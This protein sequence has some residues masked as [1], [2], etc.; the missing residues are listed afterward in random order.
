MTTTTEKMVFKDFKSAVDFAHKEYYKELP[1][2]M[3][4]QYVFFGDKYPNILEKIMSG[5]SLNEDEQKIMDAGKEYKHTVYRD[6]DVI[7]DAVDIRCSEDA[8]KE[9][10]DELFKNDVKPEDIEKLSLDDVPEATNN[11]KIKEIMV[12]QDIKENNGLTNF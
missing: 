3:V 2:H 12:E 1:R 5:G 11:K 7:E 10:I 4:E 6:D 8:P 9:L